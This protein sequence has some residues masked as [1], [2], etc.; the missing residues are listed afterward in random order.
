MPLVQT[1]LD[2][3]ADF[4]PKFCPTI[5]T[6]RADRRGALLW[7]GRA[8]VEASRQFRGEAGFPLHCSFVLSWTEKLPICGRS[9]GNWPDELLSMS[10]RVM[11]W[12]GNILPHDGGLGI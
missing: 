1:V 9:A 11:A 7:A 2:A 6:V 12:S 10:A 8:Q 3:L 5:E 4:L